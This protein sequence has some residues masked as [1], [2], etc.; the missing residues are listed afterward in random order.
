M[1]YLVLIAGLLCGLTAMTAAAR[2]EPT[3]EITDIQTNRQITGTVANLGASPDEHCVVVYVHTDVWY[4]HP[5]AA[6]GVGK[7]WAEIRGSN[8]TISTVKRD[9]PAD[10]IAAVILKRQMKGGN[11]P[12]PAKLEA[13]DGIDNQVG[14]SFI[15]ELSQGDAWHGRL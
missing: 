13:V 2:A 8:W 15:R 6:G 10:K 4:I 11:C 12:A 14:R 5:F 7:S 9:Y 1:M 3:V